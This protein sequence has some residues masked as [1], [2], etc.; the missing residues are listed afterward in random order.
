MSVAAAVSLAQIAAGT[1]DGFVELSLN[2]YDVLAG[3][4]LVREAGGWTNDF[5]G[6]GALTESHVMIASAPGIRDEL[7]RVCDFEA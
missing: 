7:L 2:I 6:A 1:L 5:L 4:V 3:I